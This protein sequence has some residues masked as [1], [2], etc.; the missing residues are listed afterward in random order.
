MSDFDFSHSNN[1][2][3]LRGICGLAVAM[4]HY[5]M[6]I[7]YFPEIGEHISIISVD[8][9]FIL[10]GYVLT[11]QVLK[12]N[13]KKTLKTFFLRR[14]MRTVPLYIIF[15]LLAN[16]LF[17]NN[18]FNLDF[19]LYF[20][21]IAFLVPELILNNYFIIAWSLCVEEIYYLVAPFISITST[22]YDKQKI[23]LISLIIFYIASL[24]F[25]FLFFSDDIRISTFMSL[26]NI[27]I[28]MI[29]K[30]FH[31]KI[32]KYFS[33][34]IAVLVLSNILLIFLL[35]IFSERVSNLVLLHIY[36]LS[37]III[38]IIFLNF[39]ERKFSI[40]NILSTS[41]YSIYLSHIFIIYLMKK[42]FLDL[43]ITHLPIYFFILLFTSRLIYYFVES[44]ILRRRPNYY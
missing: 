8:I 12:V 31:I 11:N 3:L 29:L 18:E 7:N 21:F 9:F 26:F 38:F 19:F 17:N 35:Q 24:F 42:I 1:L 15:L 39:K 2:D 23:F 10:S 32:K 14:W 22:K 37:A 34:F 44:P 41:T 36:D 43:N 13:S 33:S 16:K 40:Y 30:I 28:G 25:Y 4:G 20:S 5:F 6:H 27:M